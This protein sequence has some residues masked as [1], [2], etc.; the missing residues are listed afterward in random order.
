MIKEVEDDGDI[1][2][3]EYDGNGNQI[4]RELEGFHRMVYQGKEYVEEAIDVQIW[5]YNADGKMVKEQCDGGFNC[6]LEMCLCRSGYEPDPDDPKSCK[7]PSFPVYAI[8]LIVVGI[9]NL[10]KV[11]DYNNGLVLGKIENEYEI[12][13]VI[14]RKYA[15]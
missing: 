14:E 15:R 9:V 5:E 7:E 2:T 8:V 12:N 1:I 11:V 6:D 10:F 13:Y 4:K 3:Y